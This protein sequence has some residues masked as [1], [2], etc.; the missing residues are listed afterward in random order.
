MGI[1]V[2]ELNDYSIEFAMEDGGD[3]YTADF[4]VAY[5]P[6]NLMINVTVY[7]CEIAI[8]RSVRYDLEI[9]AEQHGNHP[10]WI[11]DIEAVEGE[12]KYEQQRGN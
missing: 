6:D 2:I 5:D 8:P 11:E 4:T 3:V 7:N 10:N 1:E 9:Y 12:K